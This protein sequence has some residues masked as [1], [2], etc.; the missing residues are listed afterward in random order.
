MTV[1]SVTMGVVIAAWVIA[2]FFVIVMLAGN[3]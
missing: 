2:A 3:R 1:Y